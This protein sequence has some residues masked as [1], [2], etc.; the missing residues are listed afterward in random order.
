[1]VQI[2]TP[3]WRRD[4]VN[5]TMPSSPLHSK[6]SDAHAVNTRTGLMTITYPVI[7]RFGQQF[8][9]RGVICTNGQS[10]SLIIRQNIGITGQVNFA[11]HSKRGR[12]APSDTSSNSIFPSAITK[13]NDLLIPEHNQIFC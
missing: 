12:S 3:P 13:R 5:C 2:I 1:M 10:K 7:S 4:G 9:V 6:S 11:V 8:N